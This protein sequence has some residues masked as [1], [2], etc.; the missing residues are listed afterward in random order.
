MN[1]NVSLTKKKIRDWRLT[2]FQ[3]LIAT[4]FLAA[5]VFSFGQNVLAPRKQQIM[6]KR[7]E[8]LELINVTEGPQALAQVNKLH[9]I[10]ITLVNAYIGQYAHRDGRATVWVG[11][12]ENNNDAVELLKRMVEG[13]KRADEGF[14]NLRTI[15]IDGQEVFQVEGPGGKHLFYNSAKSG[16]EIVWITTTEADATL[17]LKQAI[18]IF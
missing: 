8:H 6:P 2:F 17:F 11:K 5:L 7:L 9:G 1:E 10:D 3:L 4:S 14:Y 13:I 15:I 18:K 16:E 12:A